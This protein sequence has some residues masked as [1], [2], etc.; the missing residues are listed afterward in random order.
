MVQLVTAPAAMMESAVRT[1]SQSAVTMD[2]TLLLLSALMV[3]PVM[4]ELG[5]LHSANV[6]RAGRDSSAR[7]VSCARNQLHQLTFKSFLHVR[8]SFMYVV[9]PLNM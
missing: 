7:L 4:M 3:V 9:V 1:A 5:M 2:H 8:W 6:P